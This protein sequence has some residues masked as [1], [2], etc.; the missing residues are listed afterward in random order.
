MKKRLRY[1]FF[2]ASLYINTICLVR[3]EQNLTDIEGLTARLEVLDFGSDVATHF[4]QVR[5]E[6]YS[7]GEPIGPY[8]M[9]IAGH[10]RSKGFIL[11]TNNT[12]E[13]KRVDGLRIENWVS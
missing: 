1:P 6:L 9:M 7:K 12:K 11:V 5:S 3:P 10:A 13:F 4:G 8:D 2:S